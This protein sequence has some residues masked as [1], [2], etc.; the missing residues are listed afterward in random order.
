[1][2]LYI[3]LR[4]GRNWKCLLRL[5]TL[6]LADMKKAR[7][8]YWLPSCHQR[9]IHMYVFLC[10]SLEVPIA[11]TFPKKMIK[12]YAINTLHIIAFFPIFFCCCIPRAEEQKK[13]VRKFS[14]DFKVFSGFQKSSLYGFQNPSLLGFQILLCLD[15]SILLWISKSFFAWI[16]KV[17]LLIIKFKF[18]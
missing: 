7:L 18:C 3:Y 5:P 2:H 1:M 11:I 9:Y 14:L 6:S 10:W 15:F 13:E 16:S 8:F 4:I 17:F 12:S